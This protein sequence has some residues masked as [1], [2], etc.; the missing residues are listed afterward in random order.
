MADPNGT[1]HR[2]VH[3]CSGIGASP[4]QLEQPELRTTHSAPVPW[5]L[6]RTARAAAI[7]EI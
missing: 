3:T 1:L 6:P 5:R 7:N 2:R 4:W